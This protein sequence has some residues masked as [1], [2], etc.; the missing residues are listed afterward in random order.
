L[1]LARTIRISFSGAPRRGKGDILL[2]R[3]LCVVKELLGVAINKA[4]EVVVKKVERGERLR[5]EGL[6]VLTIAAVRE[7]SKRID[8]T[9]KRI[10]ETNRRIDELADTLNRRIDETNK[11]IDALYA[12]LGDVQKSIIEPARM[13]AEIHKAVMEMRAEAK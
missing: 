13:V 5:A 3:R 4:L 6:A 8:E 12:L 7:L 11:R 1:K 9:N 2:R 10:D